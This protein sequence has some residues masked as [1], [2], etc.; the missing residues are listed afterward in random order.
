MQT[1]SCATMGF[2]KIIM[3]KWQTYQPRRGVN[4]RGFMECLRFFFVMP[5]KVERKDENDRS[6]RAKFIG[7]DSVSCIMN[8]CLIQVL[9]IRTFQPAGWRIS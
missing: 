9:D 5:N 2:G 3:Y 7:T 4:Q 6:G 1:P 8:V